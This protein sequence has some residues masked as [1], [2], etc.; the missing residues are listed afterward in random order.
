MN[1][2]ILGATAFAAYAGSMADYLRFLADTGFNCIELRNFIGTEGEIDLSRLDEV[3]A[4]LSGTGLGTTVHAPVDR[5]LASPEPNERARAFAEAL[6]AIHVAKEL[7]SRVVVVHGGLHPRRSEGLALARAQLAG[8]AEAAKDAAVTL[9]LENA[10][11]GDERLF[12]Y[13]EAFEKLLDL[14]LSFVVDIG[15]AYTLGLTLADFLPVVTG[16][17]AEV[18]LHDNDGQGDWHWPL[19]TGSVPVS[20]TLDLLRTAG[21][22]GVYTIEVK[23][24]AGLAR[25]VAHLRSLG[26]PV[27]QDNR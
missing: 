12:R 11:I 8:L 17:L 15:H 26:F 25:S 19:G 21:F 2:C 6:K 5:N 14:P 16:R 9:A 27:S 3:R 13:P 24:T 4:N 18:H 10:E 20:E 23:D 22:A 7:G 1:D